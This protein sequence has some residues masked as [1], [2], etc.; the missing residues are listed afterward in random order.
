MERCG[1]CN[2][3]RSRLQ[4]VEEFVLSSKPQFEELLAQCGEWRANDHRLL[5]WLFGSMMPFVA[6]EVI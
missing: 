6:C 4:K 2:L 1:P 3:E 5:G